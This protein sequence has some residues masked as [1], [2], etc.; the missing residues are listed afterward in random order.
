MR[1]LAVALA[2]ACALGL[3]A[4][5]VAS[6]SHSQFTI[7][8]A[9][10]ELRSVDPVQREQT[11]A[12]MRSLG[13][14]WVR[15]I[16]YWHD[17][18]PHPGRH[19]RPHFDE[20]DP[21]AYPAWRWGPYDRI[22]DEAERHGMRV[23]LTVSGPVPRWATLGGDSTVNYPS[24][25]HF[26]RFMQAVGRRYGPRIDYWS[27]WNEPNHPQFLGPQSLRGRPYAPRIYRRL[28]LAARRGLRRSGNRHDRVLI[29]ETA[30]NGS[31]RILLPLEFLRG[32]LCLNR[33]YHKR[34][35]CHRL[36][37]DGWAHHPYTTRKGPFYRPAA[38]DAVM[39][40][41][42]S[43]LR[44]ALDR[45]ARAGAIR[46][47]LGIYLTEFGVQSK[48]DPIYGVSQTRQA[49]YRAIAEQIAYRN[50]RVRAFSQ[51]LMRDDAKQGR[52]YGGFESGLRFHKGHRKKAYRAFR[53]P[54]TATRVSR[55]RVR[56]WGLVRPA[57]GRARA[58]I[59][60]RDRGSHRWRRLKR[61]RTGRHGYW[62][63]RTR[64][65]RGRSYLVR[66][67]DPRGKRY[68]GS[69]T[70]VLSRR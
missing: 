51:Y 6:A 48:P 61:V 11:F 64:Y 27:V 42:L 39:I 53:L 57:R 20:R 58:E 36:D 8:D 23:L 67:R 70:R 65:R 17:V 13:V 69:R 32:V 55:H 62:R 7:F 14:H 38:R 54:M 50:P 30:P 15:V 9:P 37:A 66:W 44:R 56:L 24:S 16:L 28:F 59:A 10:H 47:H 45:A 52:R 46:R 34:H 19:S 26:A 1:R 31:G 4:A 12:E 18:A 25:T 22:I 63:A 35:G 49:E 60:Y 40:G 41:T 21:A 5:P 2:A 43:R 33:H 68:S 3:A 29:G